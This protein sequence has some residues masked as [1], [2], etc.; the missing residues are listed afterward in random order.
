[1]KVKTKNIKTNSKAEHQASL[2][3]FRI[4][5]FSL[6]SLCFLTS[7]VC[8]QTRSQPQISQDAQIQAAGQVKPQTSS[9][10]TVNFADEVNQK[11]PQIST[12]TPGNPTANLGRQ[13]WRA[14]ISVYE[15]KKDNKRKNELK[16]LIQQVR[17]IEFK[18]P[19]QPESIIKIEP[20]ETTVEA[21][22]TPFDIDVAEG[23]EKNTIESELPYEHITD[24]T[25]QMIGNIAQDPNQLDNPFKLGEVLY[26][27][28]HL[29]VAAVF[30]QEALNRTDPDK[31]ETARNRAWI[32]FQIGNCLRNDD[33]TTAQKMYKQLI[34]QYPGSPWMEPAK[35]R[36]KIIDWYLKEKPKT[37]IAESQL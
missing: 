16:Q 5:C 11:S 15:G 1:M 13:L 35:A 9:I 3:A 6:V 34:A 30:Y 22:Q 10:E 25:L 32:L 37:L 20:M 17:S 24:W 14:G 23:S 12:A 29:K 31:T 33:L 8:A 21:N 7:P 4:L 28:G 26:F 36:E 27:S 19:I 18:P 2:K